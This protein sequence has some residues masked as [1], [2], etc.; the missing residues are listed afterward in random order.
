MKYQTEMCKIA[1]CPP[2][3]GIEEQQIAYRFV[4][5]PI[6][7]KSFIPQGV[8]NPSRV[9]NTL[10]KRKCSTLALSFFISE[11]S[12]KDKFYAL[13]K[14]SKNLHKTLGSHIAK[15]V[16]NTTDG[17]RTKICKKSG[18]FDFFEKKDANFLPNFEII[19][20]FRTW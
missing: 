16:L 2:S 13:S 12:A 1:N 17:Y 20:D 15:G 9:D 18:H 10:E 8:K 14:N 7:E 11:E 6:D 3:N 19:F 5:D 4:F